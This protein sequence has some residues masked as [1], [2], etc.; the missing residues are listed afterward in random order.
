MTANGVLRVA[1]VQLGPSCDDLARNAREVAGAVNIAAD[2]GASLIVLPELAMT[3]FFA[4]EPARSHDDWA[5][6]SDGEVVKEI[7]TIAVGREVV[8]V[9]PFFEFDRTTGNRHNSAVVLGPK[10]HISMID[11]GGQAHST[12]RKLHLAPGPGGDER[13]HFTPGKALGIAAVGGAQVGTLICFD[14]RFP[15]CWRELRALGADVVAV[16]VAGE[17]GDDVDFYVGE[18]RTHARENGLSVIAANKVGVET[19]AG[20]RVRHYGESCVVDAEGTVI[21]RRGEEEGPG[22]VVADVDLDRQTR[23]RERFPYFDVRRTD[24]FGTTSNEQEVRT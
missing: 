23:T 12:V 5:Q 11:R 4:A 7:A 6:P 18:L 9:L 22:V 10:G 8:I 17:G 15:E 16:P 3:P 19:L 14:R 2:D 20:G 1:A 21:A 13:E 24:L